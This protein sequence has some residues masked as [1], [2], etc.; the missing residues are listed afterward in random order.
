MFFF[1]DFLDF[2]EF[3]EFLEFPEFPEFPEFLDFY[4]LEGFAVGAAFS[5]AGAAVGGV[6]SDDVSLAADGA[7]HAYL[8]CL[9]LVH[10]LICHLLKFGEESGGIEFA[11]FYLSEFLLP[12]SCQFGRLQER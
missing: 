5:P 3:L 8:A 6:A 4:F 7:G 11:A 12:L 1:L 9:D 2:L 10:H